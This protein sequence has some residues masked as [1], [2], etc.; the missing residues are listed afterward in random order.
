VREEKPSATAAGV[1]L[2]RVLHQKID[3]EPKI[4][5]DD[6]SERLL[7]PRAVQW[8]M[9][10]LDRFETPPSRGL[11]VHVAVRSRYS[12]DALREAEG[13]DVRQ[14]AVLGAGLDTFAYRQPR[15]AAGLRMFEVDHPASQEQKRQRLAAAGIPVPENLTFAPVNFE[16]E[17]LREGLD[18]AGFDFSRSAFFSCLGVLMYLKEPAI[19]ELFAFVGGFPKGSELVLTFSPDGDRSLAHRQLE[20]VVAE[21]GEPLQTFISEEKLTAKLRRAGFSEVHFVSPEEIATRYMRDRA[22][23]LQVPRRTTLARAR[24]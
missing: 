3:A 2:L 5:R 16:V 15:W 21:V 9:R 22:D 6:I 19:D 17:S 24:I 7:D 23:G 11:R 20:R 10:N 4:L 1:A 8:A 14:L 13:R 12:E 18:R